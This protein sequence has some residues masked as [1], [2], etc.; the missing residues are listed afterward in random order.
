MALIKTGQEI[1]ILRQAGSKLASILREAKKQA[2]PG[3]SLNQ[4]DK[5]IHQQ[6]LKKEAQPSFLGF[7]GYPK[8]TCLSLNQQVVH[9]IPDDRQLKEGDLLGIDVG[10]CYLGLYVDGAITVGV[11]IISQ[12]AKRLL[13][14]TALALARG[15]MVIR[16]GV[17]VG[18]ISQ[19]IQ[20]VA[21]SHRLGIVR[22][23]TGHGVGHQ[24]HEDPIIPNLGRKTDG[25]ILKSGMV[26]AIEPMFTA[27]QGEV[28]TEVDG[29]GIITADNSLAAQFEHTVV[30]T[31]KGAEVLTA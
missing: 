31:P 14:Y 3:V 25:I 18:E 26:L 13:K 11:G 16:P 8:A 1:D 2:I 10:L 24:V 9:A 17:R 29:W 4:L 21:E 6:I 27:G 20:V 15:I 19:A 12:E 23:L 7:E 28:L 22:A 5:S 30:I